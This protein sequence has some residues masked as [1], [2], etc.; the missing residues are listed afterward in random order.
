MAP[1]NHLLWTF[2]IL[3][4]P[5]LPEYQYHYSHLPIHP[6]KKMLEKKEGKKVWQEK[7]VLGCLE[8][9]FL[10]ISPLFLML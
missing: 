5:L 4:S 6:L 7:K 8:Y 2:A 1:Y 3:H 10:T 9:N